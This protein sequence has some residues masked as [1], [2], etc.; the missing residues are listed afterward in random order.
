M[1]IHG[2]TPSGHPRYEPNERPPLLVSASLGAQLFVTRWP[3]A[4]LL[5]VIVIREGGGS[6]DE[7]AWGI[8]AMLIMSGLGMILPSFRVGPF[9]SGLMAT[10]QPAA[11]AIPFGI[12]AIQQGGFKTLIALVVVSSLFQLAISLRLSMLRRVITPTVNGTIIVLLLITVAAGVIGNIDLSP[13]GGRPFAGPVCMFATFA[14][15]AVLI[16]KGNLQLRTWAPMVAIGV[17]WIIAGALGIY[18][19]EPFRSVPLVGIPV[20]GWPGLGFEFG[21]AFWSLLP[22]FLSVA[23]IG[24]LQASAA[25]LTTQQASWRNASALDYRRAQ[26]NSIAISMGNILCGLLSVIPM[27]LT[28]ES[29][30]FIWRT[31]CAARIVGVI[32]GS[33]FIIVALI[34]KLWALLAG[35]PTAVISMIVVVSMAHLFMEGVRLTLRDQMDYQRGMVVG[36]SVI[37][38][39]AFQFGLIP[40]PAGSFAGYALQNAIVSGGITVVVLNSVVNFT[41]RPHRFQ[42]TFD[43]SALEGMQRFLNSFA[44]DRNLSQESNERLQAVAEE[45]FLI[46]SQGHTESRRLLIKANSSAS[47]VVLEFITGP[48]GAANLED[49]IAFLPDVASDDAVPHDD[50]A[51]ELPLRLL[52]HHA[53]SVTHHQ[54][55]EVDIVTIAIGAAR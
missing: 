29:T 6:L 34:P 17:G 51:Q 49:R 50:L 38:G 30:A 1:A 45:T 42:T 8:F 39:I 4:V 47:G 20:A 9:G 55:R 3:G 18:D 36:I 27:N 52:R 32:G 24:V 15:G 16:I 35:I 12:I 2:R 7:I 11:V 48:T 28:A 25:S 43:D 41:S 10:T 23:A 54:Y 44:N 13:T 26:G 22:A 21:P 46:L 19:L 53:R 40:L 33:A 37:T 14:V 5:P 31:G